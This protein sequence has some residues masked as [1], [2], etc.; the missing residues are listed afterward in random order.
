MYNLDVTP[1][2]YVSSVGLSPDRLD[3]VQEEPKLTAESFKSPPGPTRL[4]FAW[5]G[6]HLSPSPQNDPTQI[7]SSGVQTNVD[8][9]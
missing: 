1:N 9:V 2:S 6:E 4:G 8:V 3:N 5:L 7:P